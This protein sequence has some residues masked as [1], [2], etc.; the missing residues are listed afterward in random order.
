MKK[1]HIVIMLI[2]LIGVGTGG[3]FTLL[4]PTGDVREPIE[5]MNEKIKLPEPKYDSNT[6]V[7]QALL[8]RRSVRAYKKVPLI[9]DEVSQLLWA[10][11]GITDNG[12]KFRTAPSAGALY[13][14]DVYIAIGTVEGVAQGVYKYR[15]RKHELMKVRNGDVRNELA[16]A[17]LGQSSIRESA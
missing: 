6:S 16:S 3:C 11:Q 14:L 9:L 10:A 17:A 4:E 13:P 12:S 7:E 8:E 1:I 15:P 2:A 5:P